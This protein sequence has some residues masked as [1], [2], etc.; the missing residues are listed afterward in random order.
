MGGVPAARLWELLF[1]LMLACSGPHAHADTPCTI[2]ATLALHN[3]ELPAAKQQVAGDHRLTVLTFGGVHTAG[4]NA[5]AERATYP[6]RLSAE[7]GTA[8]PEIT[9]RVVNETPPGKTSADVPAVLP[10]L[11]AKTGARLVIWGPGARDEAARL[12]LDLFTNA[13]NAGIEAVRHAGADL[14][15]LDTTFVPSP[16]RMA[17]ID[18]YRQVLISMAAAQHVPLLR[19]NDLMRQWSEDGTLNLTAQDAPERELVARRLFACVAH[20]LA[21]P[22]AEAVR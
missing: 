4:E 7:L 15:L 16:A 2:P 21:I 12:R 1:V 22:I 8:L 10:G 20:G 19:R 11:I 13:V 5:E 9:V 17:L 18:G 3:I 14:V 6:A